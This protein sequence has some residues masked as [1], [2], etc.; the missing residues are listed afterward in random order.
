MLKATKKLRVKNFE[1][2]T[3]DIETNELGKPTDFGIFDGKNFYH[4]TNIQ[5]TVE[6]I[7][8]KGGIY[9]AHC[10]MRF[11][12]VILLKELMKHQEFNISFA[13][14][15]GI[16]ITNEHIKFYDS[17]RLMPGKLSDLCNSFDVDDKK[18][19]LDVMPWLLNE[20][21]RIEYL[22]Y[23][24]ISLYQV[25][26]NFW[27]LIDEH[28]GNYR[29]VTLPSLA[30]KVWK[31]TLK[32][33][34]LKSE[35]KKLVKFETDSYFGGLCWLNEDYV[36]KDVE[37][38]VYDVNS[39][40]PYQ[41]LNYKYPYNYIGYWTNKFKKGE[42]GLYK[43]RCEYPGIPFCFDVE[44]RALSNNG[45]FIVDTDTVEY[46]CTI[47]DV[48][49][50]IGYVYQKTDYIFRDFV[51]R[52]YQLRQMG[53][54][55]LSYVAKIMLNSLYGK[56]AEKPVKRVVSNVF[57]D[58]YQNLKIYD[59]GDYELFD[60]TQECEIKHRFVAISALVTLRARL[61]LRKLSELGNLIYCDTDSLHF[62]DC[63]MQTS[64]E[65]G[66]VKH[67]YSGNAVY[68]AKKVYQFEHITKC[69]G[70]PRVAIENTDF[71]NFPSEQVFT[72][73]AFSSLMDVI[74]KNEDFGIN[75]K[76]RTVR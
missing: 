6:F 9:Y 7:L 65:L 42:L 35:S 62:T 36:R 34:F 25:I 40:Y 32:Y 46:L 45:V 2:N 38:N 16:S 58:N 70:I 31:D 68:I 67:E 21:D 17:F 66:G 23:D 72:F 51:S 37:V 56:F 57:P 26:T 48:K 28:F 11:D 52:G 4:S 44:T 47:C 43:I 22:K 20:V 61:H 14:T 18:I 27:T 5:E 12:Y 8:K 19:K 55:G 39:M 50:E 49:I 71:S 33:T 64:N 24:C 29:A 59:G 73:D 13:G 10:G 74:H 76:K 30:L 3:I 63:T 41:M 1:F 53:L 15:N 69:K 54:P 75:K 60:F